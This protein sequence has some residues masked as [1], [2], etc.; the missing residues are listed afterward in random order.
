MQMHGN[1][2]GWDSTFKVLIGLNLDEFVDSMVKDETETMVKVFDH[3]NKV[4]F[5]DKASE[6]VCKGTSH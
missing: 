5:Y 3:V 2:G 6:S 4:E 1:G